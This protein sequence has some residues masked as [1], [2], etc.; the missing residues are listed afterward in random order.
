MKNKQETHGARMYACM[1]TERQLIYTVIVHIHNPL[2][3]RVY[4]LLTITLCSCN[5]HTLLQHLW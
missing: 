5:F 2:Q 1:Y 4:L 3:L